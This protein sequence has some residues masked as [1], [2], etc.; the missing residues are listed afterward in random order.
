MRFTTLRQILAT[1][2]LLDRGHIGHP[3]LMDETTDSN[4][5]KTAVNE[6]YV[7]VPDVAFT[8]LSKAEGV[9]GKLAGLAWGIEG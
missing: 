4:H 7:L 2:E 6:L 5:S 9:E 1:Q 8:V 3:L